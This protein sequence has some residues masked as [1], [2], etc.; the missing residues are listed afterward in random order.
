VNLLL[1]LS[2]YC[3]PID[4][5]RNRYNQARLAAGS[6]ATGTGRR[7][8]FAG[9]S[10]ATTNSCRRRSSHSAAAGAAVYNSGLDA[11]PFGAPILEPDLDL[12]LAQS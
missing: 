3:Q 9:R 4:V 10:A 1:M 11:F 5:D 2:S 6:H 12:D 8:S 7:I